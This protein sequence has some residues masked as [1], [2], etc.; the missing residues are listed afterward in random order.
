MPTTGTYGMYPEDSEELAR[1]QALAQM[2]RQQSMSP[3]ETQSVGGIPTPISPLQGLS[4]MFE[5]YQ[6]GK[7]ERE[8]VQGRKEASN[9]Y[10]E[11]LVEALKQSGETGTPDALL[12]S[13]HPLA[14]QIGMS[15]M[16]ADRASKAA[17][18]KMKSE[19][20]LKKEFELD[21][22]VISAKERIRR[23]GKTD[24]NVNTTQEKEESKT[25]GKGFG[26]QYN[27][28]QESALGAQSKINRVERLDQLLQGVDTGKL[29]PVG[30][31]IAGYAQSLGLKVDPKL[32][33][34]QAAEALSNELALELRNPAG[35]AGMPGALSDKDR[36]FLKSMVPGIEKTSQGRKLITDSYRKLA[37]R[38]VEV[39]QLARDY[40]NKNGQMNEGFYEE[41][42]KYSAA[43]PL[44]QSPT[45]GPAKAG[46]AV[47]FLGFE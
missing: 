16:T 36:E 47:K 30:A 26:E 31:E 2:L 6:S 18:D 12:T 45:N 5:G 29:T 9:R 46:G 25:V 32:G 13:G 37:Q 38:D 44:F 21:P 1:K 14:Q 22:D 17:V 39:A 4:K 33:N 15:Q 40:R 27:K 3:I 42:R 19:Y 34:I 24:V 23:A 35:G 43:K 11:G 8:A 10:R 28:L 20:G 41:L 7:I